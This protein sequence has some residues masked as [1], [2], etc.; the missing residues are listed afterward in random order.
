[1]AIADAKLDSVPLVAITGQVSQN[2]IGS[3]A[4]Q[5]TPTISICQ[6]IT[7][8][9]YMITRIEDVARVVKEAFYVAASGRPG[10]VLIDFPK[11]VQLARQDV[12]PDF[13]PPQNLPGFPPEAL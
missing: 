8:H 12:V 1:T 3:D 9:H 4:F 11:D 13:D 2:V 5:E 6:S 10:P 7:K